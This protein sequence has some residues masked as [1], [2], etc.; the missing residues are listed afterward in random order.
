MTERLPKG[1]SHCEERNNAWLLME[2][3]ATENE[4]SVCEFGRGLEK[5]AEQIP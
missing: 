1:P 5:D 3:S 4:V 2:W